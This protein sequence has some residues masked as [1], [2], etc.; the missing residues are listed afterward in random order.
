MK[1]Y[2]RC[3]R[4]PRMRSECGKTT[5]PIRIMA[6][7]DNGEPYLKIIGTRDVDAIIQSH[8]DDCDINGIVARYE[9][10]DSTVLSSLQGFYADLTQ[11]SC[12]L[13]DAQNSMIKVRAY[14][15]SMPDDVR[16]KFNTLTKFLEAIGTDE[17]KSMIVPQQ[18]VVDEEK[19][20][21]KDADER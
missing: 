11:V 6:V 14:Y 15:E 17:L 8:A 21:A 7:D 1:F 19:D 13:Q 5:A 16:K 18:P 3:N 10:G 12:N 2:S 4:P 20:G 9:A